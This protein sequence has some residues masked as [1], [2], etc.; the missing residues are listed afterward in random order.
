MFKISLVQNILR[1]VKYNK[2]Q[3][4]NQLIPNQGSILLVSP[5]IS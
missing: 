5:Q 1:E 3:F 2:V 4:I